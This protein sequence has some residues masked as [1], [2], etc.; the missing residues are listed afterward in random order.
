MASKAKGLA[1]PFSSQGCAS[2]FSP[3]KWRRES[4]TTPSPMP[5]SGNLLF[6]RGTYAPCSRA[7]IWSI[8]HDR[9]KVLAGRNM[10]KHELEPKNRIILNTHCVKCPVRNRAIC[11]VLSPQISPLLVRSMVHKRFAK[12]E[13]IWS[14]GDSTAYFSIIVS[15]AV[16]LVKVL[17]DGRQ[18]IVGMLF[19]SDCLGDMFVDE[20]TS[21]AESVSDTELCCFP[22]KEFER[23]L[24]SD[25]LLEHA[26]LERTFRDLVATR[27][28]LAMIGRMGALERVSGFLVSLMEKAARINCKHRHEI[29]RNI[30]FEIPI[31]RADIA[32]YLGLTLETVSR[33]FSRL[34]DDGII[35]LHDARIIEVHDPGSLCKLAGS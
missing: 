24:E 2:L 29:D 16:K 6:C 8:F 35:S 9:M 33:Q 22:Q 30:L 20:H 12:R 21:F 14:E 13:I 23:A 15:G 31:S 4:P 27:K 32:D 19:A 7:A 3:F 17:S 5:L 10:T 1:A 34:R 26:L 18:Q 25:P 28:W 11:S